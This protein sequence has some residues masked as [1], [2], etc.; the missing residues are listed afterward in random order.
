MSSLGQNHSQYNFSIFYKITLIKTLKLKYI[1]NLHGNQKAVF[2]ILLA[3][4]KILV[5]QN[6]IKNVFTVLLFSPTDFLHLFS[7]SFLVLVYLL[8]I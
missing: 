4:I 6:H 2:F 1:K 7:I 8:C 3:I 5:A